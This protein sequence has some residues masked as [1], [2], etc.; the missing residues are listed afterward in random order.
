MNFNLIFSLLA[1]VEFGFIFFNMPPVLDELML[2]YGLSYSGLSV[3][4]S[5]LVWSHAALQIPAGLIADRIGIRRTL[6]LGLACLTVGNLMATAAPD[7]GLALAGR[8]VTGLG[9]GL[10]FITTMKL[11]AVS[12][13]PGRAGTFQSFFAAGCSVGSLAAFL[14][15]PLLFKLSWQWIYLLPGLTSPILL[16]MLLGLDMTPTP[17]SASAQV[18]LGS[19]LRLPASWLIG[20]MHALC[21]GTVV[22]VGSWVPALLADVWGVKGA[23]QF[24]W[25]G[26][27]VM[28]ASGLGRFSGGLI[29]LRLSSVFVAR[30]GVLVLAFLFGAIFLGLSPLTILILVMAAAWFASVN[31]GAF[32]DLAAQAVPSESMASM[33][34]MVNLLGNLGVIIFTLL[35]GF[36]K[37]WLG[38]FEWGFIVLG[39]WAV[40]IFV[41]SHSLTNKFRPDSPLPQKE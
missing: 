40:A 5:A 34:G 25:G 13:P 10:S 39:V 20:L 23:S 2:L 26:A 8:I 22:S 36:L 16:I 31:A 15:V 12:A 7:F 24:A 41:A 14:V 37:D 33:F 17:A 18:S 6:V 28:V 32:F 9:M 38:G 35:F 29:L 19:I 3:L 21:W 1:S 11:I 27:L 30:G 4:L